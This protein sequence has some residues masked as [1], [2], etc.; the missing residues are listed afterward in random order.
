MDERLERAPVGVL[1]VDPDG[2]VADANEA[3][4]A[5]LDLAD[6]AGGGDDDDGT[7]A[8]AF[9]R[10]VEDTLHHAFAGDGVDAIAFEEFYPDLDR[11]L[12]VDVEPTGGDGAT[13]YVQDVTER[14]RHEQTAERLREA[15]E[16]TAAVD[17]LLSD[18][19]AELVDAQSRAAVAET[20]CT[21]LG[22]VDR[23]EFAWVGER[24][25]GGSDDDLTV[26]AA[27]GETGETFAAVREAVADD[28]VETPEE[29]AVETGELQAVSAL[30]EDSRVPQAVRQAGFADGVQSAL[31]IPL[32]HGASVY[33]VVGVYAG[34]EGA[35][36]ERERTSFQRLGEVAGF[37]VTASRTRSLLA[38]DA[39][40]EVTFD[41]GRSSVLAS[42]SAALDAEVDL[43]GLVP[44]DDG[45][46]LCYVSVAA[47]DPEAVRETAAGL[48]GV[49]D[50]RV[51]RE[52]GPAG[53]VELAVV[54]ETPL[55]VASS[56]GA[57]V[58]NAAFE[59]GSGRVVAA[60]PPDADVHRM[61]EAVTRETAAEVVA[62]RERKRSVQ[63]ARE[64]R[65]GLADRL[66]DR[67]ETVLRAAYHAAYFE[68]PRG[69]TAEEV[70]D[71]LG[72]AGSTLLGH[73][74]AAQRKL[75]D[76]FFESEDGGG[77]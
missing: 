51:V 23:Y 5:L 43:R 13:V 73:L 12:A 42:L 4:R 56:L 71:S 58:R 68:S 22:R 29:R 47:V 35:F 41:V 75:L 28:A 50:A 72:I 17:D 21:A 25:V 49:A 38:A 76:E 14:R 2:T 57:T 11:W 39:V 74:R 16:R 66:T 24:A 60:F 37:A 45:E 18:V 19:L 9:P 54:G 70:A 48:D 44:H 33:G 34:S 46:L 20:I 6:D 64:F 40:A 30:A 69:S 36:S 26:R 67:Q 61:A 53:A 8:E 15:R 32:V 55:L 59:G 31:A 3:A 65:T 63:T 7:L 77:E 1:A 10:S 52:D 62:K 27:E